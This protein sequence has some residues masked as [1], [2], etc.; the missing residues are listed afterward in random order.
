MWSERCTAAHT[1]TQSN[2]CMDVLNKPFN[3][4]VG[5][6]AGMSHSS[7]FYYYQMSF[8]AAAA[9]ATAASPAPPLS[10]SSPCGK[11]P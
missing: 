10:P 8:Q 4:P 11:H 2:D 6:R 9:A 7:D 3:G 5:M 1:H